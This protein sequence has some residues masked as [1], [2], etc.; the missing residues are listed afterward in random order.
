M[1]N[2]SNSNHDDQILIRDEMMNAAASSTGAAQT[3]L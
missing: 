1:Y 2:N 3:P